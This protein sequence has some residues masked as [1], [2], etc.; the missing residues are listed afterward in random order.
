[1]SEER[2]KSFDFSKEEVVS[3]YEKVRENK[4]G[5]GIDK[6]SISEF[7][8]DLERNVYKIWNRL[9]SGS[10]MPPSVKQVM[11]PKKQGGKRPLGIPTVGDRVAQGVLK[12]RLES[13]LEALFHRDSYGYRPG[14][15]AH[16]AIQKCKDNCLQYSWVIDLDIKGFFDNISHEW[17]MKMV[18]HHTEEKSMLLY[19]E[20]WLKCDVQLQDGTF[21]KRTKGTPQGGVISPL[22]SNLYLHHGFDMWMEKHHKDTPFERYADDIVIHCRSLEQA[23]ELLAKIKERLKK[24]DLELHEEKTK[25]VYCKDDRRK[26]SHEHE[27]FTFLSYS[28][29]P[30]V[31]RNKTTKK[32]FMIFVPAIS[33]SA[34]THVRKRVR[35]VFNPRWTETDIE[36]TAAILNPR[37]RGWCNYY[38]KSYPQEMKSI[39]FYIDERLRE[40]LRNKFRIGIWKSVNMLQNLMQLSKGKLF[41]HWRYYKLNLNTE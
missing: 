23:E 18:R 34:K 8:K 12:A 3:S 19:V 1:M 15:S 25:I 26:G 6:E 17:M 41:Y 16:D 24:F 32:L 13:E 35:E 31:L 30:R 28:F 5:S 9:S 33:E 40:W 27:S 4:G 7:E 38:S 39:Y 29:Q 37:I 14:R 21:I 22:L 36:G 11:I 2:T 20:R 10:Y